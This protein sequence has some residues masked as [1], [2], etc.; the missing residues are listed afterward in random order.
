MPRSLLKD[1]NLETMYSMRREGMNNVQI[2]G[3]LGISRQTVIRY[4]G[5]QPKELNDYNGPRG[6]RGPRMK[7]APVVEEAPPACLVVDARTISLTGMYGKYELDV[8]EGRIDIINGT[9]QEMRVNKDM[10]GDFINELSAIKRKMEVLTF[11]NEAW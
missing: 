5:P 8:K 9:G 7:A 6:P 4:I 2:A 10:L 1:I 11:E 3:A